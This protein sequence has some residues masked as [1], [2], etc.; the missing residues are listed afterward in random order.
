MLLAFILAGWG[1]SLSDSEPRP[2]SSIAWWFDSAT[3]AVCWI[4]KRDTWVFHEFIIDLDGIHN[5]GFSS[6]YQWR[7]DIGNYTLHMTWN[8]YGGSSIGDE[9]DTTISVLSEVAVYPPWP[10]VRFTDIGVFSEWFHPF[11]TKRTTP[12]NWVLGIS[13]DDGARALP[14]RRPFWISLDA[15]KTWTQHDP[16]AFTGPIGECREDFKTL[17]ATVDFDPDTVNPGSSGRWVTVYIELPSG[18]DPRE[19]NASTVLLNDAVSPVLD[20]KYGFVSDPTGYIVDHDHDG[21]EERMLRFDRGKVVAVLPPGTNP[22]RIAGNLA[23]GQAFE[24][25]SDPIRLLDSPR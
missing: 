14:I 8:G 20:P 21:M 24:G 13:D 19:I 16:A 25:L 4:G 9:T 11:V 7:A 12:T 1:P 22:V 23:I 3:G 18:H 10:H 2:R 17:N 5:T 15:G 6:A